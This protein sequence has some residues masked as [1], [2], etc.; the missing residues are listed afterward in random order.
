MDKIQATGNRNKVL[1][2]GMIDVAQDG[3]VLQGVYAPAVMVRDEAERDALP[4]DY[5]PGTIAFTPGEAQKWQKTQDG[6]WADYVGGSG[7]SGA[8]AATQSAQAAAASAADRRNTGMDKI[9]ATGNRNKVLTGGMIDVAQDGSVLQGVYAPAVMVRDEAERD[10]LPADYPPGTIAFTPGE[11]QKWQKTQ[12]GAWADY[13]GGGGSGSAQDAAQSAQDAAQSA[14][15]AAQSAQDAAQSAQDAEQSAQEAAQHTTEHISDWLDNHPEATTT[16]QDGSITRAKLDADLQEKTDEVS[17]LKSAIDTLVDEVESVN[18]VNK[19]KITGGYLGQGCVLN[20]NAGLITEFIKVKPNTVYS[21]NYLTFGDTSNWVSWMFESDDLSTNISKVPSAT[22][23]TPNNC[24]Y[25]RLVYSG[26]WTA[27]NDAMLVEGD[28][29]PSTY[30]PYVAPHYDYSEELVAEITTVAEN[31]VEPIETDVIENKERVGEVTKITEPYNLIDPTKN[32]TGYLGQDCVLR[33]NA[34]LITD[35][36]EVTPNTEYTANHLGGFGDTSNW[37]SWM[38]E[39]ADL[40]SK[41]GKI[42]SATFTTPANCHYVRLVYA[43]MFYDFMLIEGDTML[44]YVPYEASHIEFSDKLSNAILTDETEN[45]FF[46]QSYGVCSVNST[47]HMIW[48]DPNGN[49]RGSGMF[50]IYPYVLYKMWGPT[51]AFSYVYDEDYNYLFTISND[52]I[53][54][55]WNET[56]GENGGHIFTILNPNAY[57][58][59]FAT[60]KSTDPTKCYIKAYSG[61]DKLITIKNGNADGFK[62]SSFVNAPGMYGKK[63]ACLGDSI[64][65]GYSLANPVF[66]RYSTVA[67]S[68]CG[69][70][71][72]NYGYAGSRITA[73]GEAG[74][75]TYDKSMVIRYESMADGMDYITVMGGINDANNN[76]PI[77]EVGDT[78]IYTFCGAIDTM[79][80]GLLAKYP[81]KGI[82]FIT[83]LHY[84]DNGDARILPY[85]EAMKNVCNRYAIPVLDLYNDGQLSTVT[86]ALSTMYYVDGLHPNNLGHSVLARKIANF[87]NSL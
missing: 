50:R 79:I 80:N 82:G 3:S 61:L 29:L 13:V 1:T 28:T 6:A 17:E 15:D 83:P 69:V 74:D 21:A 47:D 12:D 55:V 49:M 78:S 67:Q 35:F 42:P 38:F 84:D 60:S 37:V 76:L 40:S 27:A 70:I 72:F 51:I 63:W 56:A 5:P 18:K 85:V 75:D 23:T 14:Q 57:Y 41:I 22:F 30:V 64:T 86:S 71:A 58:A 34:G 19:D 53:N 16:V 68:L 20:T 59:N 31:V 54:C 43:S 46:D 26:G 4:A 8:Q 24:N 7:S 62:F 81:G 45:E 11:A 73:Q 65:Q 9:Q 32:T 48:P 2:G 36:I 39:T 10:A 66:Y 44:P 87:L 33:T 77:G 52:G 25:V